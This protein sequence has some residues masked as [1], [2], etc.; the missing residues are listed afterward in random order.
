[1]SHVEVKLFTHSPGPNYGIESHELNLSVPESI[2]PGLVELFYNNPETSV[3]ED[4]LAMFP[5]G[6]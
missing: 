5:V 2:A 4:S 1:M 3:H 6:D